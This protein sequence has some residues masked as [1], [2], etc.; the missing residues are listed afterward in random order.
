MHQYGVRDVERLLRLPRSTIRAL[1]AAGFVSPGRGPRNTLRFSF[2]DLIV[3]RTAQALADAKVPQ[4]RITKSVKDLR[5]HLP[6]E[7]PLSGLSICAVADRVV[8]RE[9]GSRWQADSGQYLLAFEGDPAD[10]SLSVIERAQTAAPSSDAEDWFD[11]AIALERED[12]EAALHAYEQAV[13]ADPAR[14][15]ARINLGRIL[16]EAGRFEKAERVYRDAMKACGS[17]PML[18]YN[19]GVLLDDMDRKPEAMQAYEAALRGNPGLADGHYNLALLCERLGKPKEAIRHMSQY[20]R[21]I[22]RPAP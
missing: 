18:L 8:V 1:I 11:K 22:G 15:D 6:D 2:Q 21:L 12:A 17:D 9:G 13:A 16:H 14:I 10:G 3:L 19:L 4:R 5:R 7:M 20:R